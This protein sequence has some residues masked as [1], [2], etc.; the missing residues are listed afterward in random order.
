VFASALQHC[1][2]VLWLQAPLLWYEEGAEAR[3]RV[4]LLRAL[5]TVAPHLRR[6]LHHVCAGIGRGCAQAEHAETL[7]G[8]PMVHSAIGTIAL[9]GQ[10]REPADPT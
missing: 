5:V 1:A 2:R 9:S 6:D 3:P 4:S 10:S 7:R 8:A